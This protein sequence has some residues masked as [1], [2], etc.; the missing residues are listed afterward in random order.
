MAVILILT[1]NEIGE[2][3]GAAPFVRLPGRIPLTMIQD[4]YDLPTTTPGSFSLF[5]RIVGSGVTMRTAH[6]VHWGIND[7]PLRH[8]C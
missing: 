4:A 8:T 3:C 5:S 2:E 1:E 6:I 7:W